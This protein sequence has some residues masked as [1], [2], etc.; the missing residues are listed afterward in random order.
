MIEIENKIDVR[1][2]MLKEFEE[3]ELEWRVQSCGVKKT[4]SNL[5][6]KPWV[7]V[8]VYVQARA[9]QNRLDEVFGWENWTEE[10]REVD[11]SI[12]CRLGVYYNDRWIYKENGAS[13]TDIEAFKGGISG[14]F[15]RVASS[16]FGIGRY[17]YKIE[18]N[19]AECSLEKKE[20]YTEKAKTKDGR[21]IYWKIPKIKKDYTI[22]EAQL[23]L[24]CTLQTKANVSDEDIKKYLFDT[25][26]TS[27]RKQL[28]P[29][30][31]ETVINLLQKKINKNKKE[32]V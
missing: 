26:K 22:N 1:A 11:G 16:G 6:E 29:V 9:I 24:L 7:M 20:G 10:Y 12:V 32:A 2:E 31:F 30:Q 25:F 17:L 3:N 18:S 4:K 23:K 21:Y 14:A 5:V 8:L 15:K 13:K 28:N 19:F 27:S